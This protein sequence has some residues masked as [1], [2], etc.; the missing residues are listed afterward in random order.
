MLLFIAYSVNYLHV[1][2]SYVDFDINSVPEKLLWISADL[3]QYN[4]LS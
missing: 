2:I 4:Q 3:C 1:I